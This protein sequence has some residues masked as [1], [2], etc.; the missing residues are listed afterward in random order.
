MARPYCGMDEVRVFGRSGRM[1]G[2]YPEGDE[3]LKSGVLKKLKERCFNIR[4]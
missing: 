1:F 4:I 2:F 3:G